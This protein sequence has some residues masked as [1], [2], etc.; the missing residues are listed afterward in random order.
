VGLPEWPY[1]ITLVPGQNEIYAIAV[2]GAGNAST[3]SNHIT[4]ELD[5]SPGLRI[6]Q[7]FVADDV[8][9]INLGQPAS[10]VTI[11]IYDMGGK[12]VQILRNGSSGS[13]ISVPWDG[14]NGDGEIVKKGPLVAVGQ[15]DYQ[16]GGSE[17][18]REI[19]LFEP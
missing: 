2:D 19:F 14:K 15:I 18:F 13:N 10:S 3:E 6:P 16:S 1:P 5:A 11:R 8:F 12:L 9:L 17:V 7:P 4:V